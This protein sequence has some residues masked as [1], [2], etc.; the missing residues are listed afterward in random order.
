[1]IPNICMELSELRDQLFN[2]FISRTIKLL[3]QY[4]SKIRF[5]LNYNQNHTLLDWYDG[6][7]YL[8]LPF[9]FYRGV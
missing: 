1:M 4:K 3:I 6:G 2:P 9:S 8:S 7:S 5:S